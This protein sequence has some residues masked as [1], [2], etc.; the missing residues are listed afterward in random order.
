MIRDPDG[1]EITD[2]G[3][4]EIWLRSPSTFLGYWR[5]EAASDDVLDPDGWYRTG[6]FGR[7]EDGLLYVESRLRDLIIRGGENIY[8]IEIENRL[9]GHP[10]I[11]D[12]A[13]I[14]VSHRELGQEVM[15]VIVPREGA[16][17]DADGVRRWVATGLAPFKVP[18]HVRVVDALPYGATGKVAKLE[19]EERFG[20]GGAP[21][22]RATA[23]R[24]SENPDET[25]TPT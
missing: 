21:A 11:A 13:V 25:A 15:A 1:T 23:Q 5:D 24:P 9:L 20:P 19:L 10:D 12:A 14:G 16:T 4:G 17:V 7:I 22:R 2:G 6:D 18:A 3:I 8:P